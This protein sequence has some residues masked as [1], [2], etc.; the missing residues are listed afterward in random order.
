MV[1][2][3]RHEMLPATLHVDEPSPHVDWSAGSVS[4]L[5]EARPWKA[6]PAD[7]RPRRAG[8]SSFGISGTNAHVIVEAAPAAEPRAAGPKPVMLPFVVSAKSASALE[9][10]AARLAAHVRADGDLDVADVAWTLAGRSNFEHRAVVVG[11]DR[12]RLLAGLDELAGGRLAGSV[13][14]G[15]AAPAGK[16]VF[17]FPGQGSQ[18]LGMGIELLDTAP[19]FAQQIEACAQ[20]FAE[21]VDWSLIDVLR[22]APGA[23]ELDR[24]DV[25]QPVLFAVMVSLAELWKSVGVR[26]DAVIGHSQGEIA[27]AY[28]AG[29]LSLR[30][31]A[32]VVTLRSKLLRSLAN[33][34]GMLSIAC[35]TERARELLAPYGNRVSIAA[36]NGRSAVVVSGDVTALDELVGFC[37]DLELR[38]RRIDVDYASHSVEVEAIH[39][40]LVAAL[41]GIGPQ[42]S[43]TAFFS[44]V[45]GNRL[46]TAGLDAEY[47]YRNIRQTVQF[48]QAV[49]SACEHGYRTFIESSPH[50][51]LIAGIEDTASVCAAG[52]SPAGNEAVVVP[53]LGRDDG[54]LE[55]FLTSAAAAFV[56]GVRVDWRGTL[57]GGFVELPT[58][59]F[60]RRRFWLS[61]EGITADVAGLG[62][63]TSEHPLLSAVVELPASGGVLMTGRLSPSVQGWL[64]DHAVSGV[65]V[66]P[67]SGF[68]ELAIRAGDEAGCPT[69]DE[70]T[71]H[72]PLTLPA[73]DSG[74]GSVPVQVVVGSAEESGQRAVSI[75]SRPDAGAGWVCHAEGT[76]STG[77]V[78]PGADLSVWPPAGAVAADPADGYEQLAARG[79]GYGPAF[80]GLT[81]TWVRGDE[82]FA[83]VRLPD[84]AGGVNGFGVHP[85]LLDAA[86]HALVMGH[87][88]A[89]RTDDVV[90]PFSWQGVSLHAAGA[91]AVRARIAPAGPTAVSIE[92]ADGLGLPVLSVRAM[93]ARPVSERQLRAAVS[94]AGP[95]RLFEVVWSPAT[96]TP[97]DA[98]PA[99]QILEALATDQ[100][101]VAATYRR[102]HQALAAVQSW[103]TEHDSEV[104]VVATRG[105][106]ALAGEDITDL[107]GAAVW[108]LVRSAQ[109]EHPGRIV[110]VDSDAPLDDHAVANVLA[111]GEPQ[112]LWR[113][114]T[115][116]TARVHGSRAVDGIMV[117]PGDGPWR[118]GISSAGTFENLCLEPVPNAG[119]PLEPG[120]VRVA[121][122]AIATNFR[123]MMITLGMFTHDGSARRRRRRRGGRSGAGVTEFAVGDSVYGFFPDGSGTLVAGDI[124]LL[125][126]KPAD[127]SYAEAAAISAVFTT[128]Y[129]AFIHLAEV[130][131]GQRVLVH[132]AA[133]GVGMAAVQLARHLGL[134]V[135]GT[136]SRGKWDTL[137]AMGFDDDH[138]GDSRTLD[139]EEKFRAVTG[140]AA[141]TWCWTRW[142]ANSSMPHYGWSL[143]AGCSW[144]WARPTSAIR[145]RWPRNIRAC[146][147]APSTFSSPADR[148]CTSGCSSSPGCSMPGRSSRCR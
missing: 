79:Y 112:I 66:F 86:M 3:M 74:S 2:A 52:D 60:D 10:Q 84:A 76:L 12:D 48:D 65:V 73:K 91:S 116:Y 37:A 94:G 95:D 61:G 120:Q 56:A 23:P 34:G 21:F 32:R 64:A 140:G 47:W 41:T 147:I 17:V 135:F 69:V 122:R 130:R 100:E 67:G 93:V 15:T 49:R 142:P 121:L 127:W 18:W 59:A 20:A 6:E 124:R 40:E 55:R 146:A 81:A 89:G 99:H 4:L 96:S 131:P 103:L 1:Q 106:V 27:A 83:E 113:G 28:V 14:Q 11:G 50:P 70:L 107:A 31:A 62:L 92:L 80:Q 143:P 45:T 77:S 134:E 63:G 105:A 78:E 26:P 148:G 125:L 68:V 33:P 5:T 30:D 22:G 128:A 145:V 9:S 129:M 133:G 102:T 123:D 104:L 36:V 72:A 101:P 137:R 42:T 35:S 109:T 139:F 115:A 111:V 144:R 114:G 71:L 87:H 25:V 8:V 108:G 29:A 24:V 13:I 58:Y 16:T 119:A 126:P 38:T 85:A 51:A 110:L 44:T 88:S 82:V 118:L 53:T 97:S 46:D 39:G 75:F 57:E 138:I 7:G 98:T 141:W 90:L 117:P 136:A 19:V 54:G 43:R 132:A